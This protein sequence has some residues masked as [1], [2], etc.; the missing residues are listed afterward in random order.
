M[1]INLLSNEIIRILIDKQFHSKNNTNNLSK[2]I[3][4]LKDIA[5]FDFLS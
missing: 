4:N 5:I 1:I 2:P 3:I